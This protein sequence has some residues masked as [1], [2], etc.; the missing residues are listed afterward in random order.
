MA[1]KYKPCIYTYVHS[2]KYKTII[3]VLSNTQDIYPKQHPLPA[4]HFSQPLH[5]KR[6]EV[7]LNITL[8]ALCCFVNQP[9]LKKGKHVA[10]HWFRPHHFQTVGWIQ[11]PKR[12]DLAHNMHDQQ[13]APWPSNAS[14]FQPCAMLL[15]PFTA[16]L[17]L[18]PPLQRAQ[19]TLSSPSSLPPLDRC[20]LSKVKF[21]SC[22]IL[23]CF[24]SLFMSI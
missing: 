7:Y 5:P 6:M 12:L 15:I 13:Q 8:V 18:S 23:A 10:L 4:D 3:A 21:Q 20:C 17:A 19:F 24:T 11:F 22:Y 1:A 16:L 14:L 2:S 9:P